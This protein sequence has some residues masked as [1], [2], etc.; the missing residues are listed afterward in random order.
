MS[1]LWRDIRYA[2]RM[3]MRQPGFT[4]V[5]VLTLALGIGANAAIFSIVDATILR[6]LPLPNASRI[7]LV[8][9]NG[10]RIGGPSISMP[11][12]LEWQ[13]KSGIFESLGIL[14]F[15]G[16]VTL[17]EAGEP[18]Q[19][20]L[21]S[22]TPELFKALGAQPAIGRTFR[23]EEAQTGGANVVILSDD[24]WR[25]RF[26]GDPNVIGRAITLET[27]SYNVIGVMPRDFSLPLPFAQN[28]QV[29]LPLRVPASS[30]NP[31]Y[32]TWCIGLLKA[33]V[34]ISQAEG[35]LTPALPVL[36]Q[37]YPK[38]IGADE[39]ARVQPLGNYVRGWYGSAPLLLL[40]AVGLVLLIACANVANLLLARASGRTREMAI[41]LS[42]GAA[43]SRLVRQLLTES[44]VLATMGGAAGIL[45]CYLCFGIVL[46][47]VPENLVLIGAISIDARV[48]GFT[49]AASVITGAL[50]GL[51]PAMGSSKADLHISLKEGTSRSGTGRERG[52]LRSALILAE[53]ALAVVL[54]VGAT[55]LLESFGR[56][57]NVKPGFDPNN[58]LTLDIALPRAQFANIAS[59]VAFFEDFKNQVLSKPD[60]VDAAFTS[61]APFDLRGGDLLFSIEGPA[62]PANQDNNDADIRF[63][64]ADYFRTMKIPVVQGRTIQA[65]DAAGAEPI[66]VINQAMAKIYFPGRNAIGEQVWVGKPMGP[67]WAEPSP[68]RIVGIVADIHEAS[69]TEPSDPTMYEPYAQMK[70][71]NFATL[72]VR[73]NHDPRLLEPTLRG[74]IQSAL[75]KRA[76]GTMHTIEDS[77]SV[78]V[79][80]E[81]FRTTLL[82]IFAGLG[83]L[84]VTVGVYGVIAYF[85]AQRTHEIGVRMALG[86]TR[87]SVLRLV[88]WQGLRL[89]AVGAA[90]GVAASLVLGGALRGMLYGIA[91]NDP[92]TLV[93]AATAMMLIALAACWIPARRATKVDPM[94]ALRYE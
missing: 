29:W 77:I 93:G 46:R 30:T 59:Q 26:G 27:T 13:K 94:V 40:G 56:M 74:M 17:V 1:E 66:V 35:M 20:K 22:A 89:A 6:P 3:L 86:A 45:I 81:R 88:L 72:V 41:R 50:F 61:S 73:T 80:D 14:R 23:P 47:L 83:L 76:V 4:A 78:S 2:M 84:I 90:V 54:L 12:F 64:N 38:M 19:V 24:L 92:R 32:G 67:S 70:D 51:A 10:N 55:L 62:A 52:R 31:V 49:L 57:M 37:S 43:R 79:T 53:V 16:D 5:A 34:P 7:M 39:T 21:L 36:S 11:I 15:N 28:A 25:K 18:K 87:T 42:M 33:G 75:P 91:P 82:S 60:V 48:L 44:M 68:R 85:V 63:A 8:R 9:R 65:S 58:V 69:L 71:G